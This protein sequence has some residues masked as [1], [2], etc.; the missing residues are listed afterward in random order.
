MAS[1]NVCSLGVNSGN[2]SVVRDIHV[3]DAKADLP[4]ASSGAIGIVKGNNFVRLYVHTGTK[5]KR[6]WFDEKPAEAPEE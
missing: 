5:W 6:F 1:E 3:A 2:G 4:V